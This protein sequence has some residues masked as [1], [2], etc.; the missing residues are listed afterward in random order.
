MKK[1]S[2]VI[3]CGAVSNAVFAHCKNPTQENE[4][5]GMEAA[6]R[7]AIH[8]LTKAGAKYG[9]YIEVSRRNHG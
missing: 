8:Y 5:K 2:E 4:D 7:L 1:L 9:E 6:E 3:L